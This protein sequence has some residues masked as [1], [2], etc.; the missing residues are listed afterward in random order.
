ME[1]NTH[2]YLVRIK[3][4][5][6]T[7]LST[8]VKS[9][10]CF[11]S[12]MFFLASWSLSSSLELLF[13]SSSSS[14]WMLCHF[15]TSEGILILLFLDCWDT[16]KVIFHAKHIR[17]VISKSFEFQNSPCL[18]LIFWSCLWSALW[19]QGA[20]RLVGQAATVAEEAGQEEVV[21]EVHRGSWVRRRRSCPSKQLWTSRWLQTERK[22]T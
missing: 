15:F 12:S 10:W 13:S 5:T 22:T 7:Q 21:E 2:L 8:Y 20:H 1:K 17:K 16:Q 14:F 19:L 11:H 3:W 6:S 9:C 18:S 4:Q